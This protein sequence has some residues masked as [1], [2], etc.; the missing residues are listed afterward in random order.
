MVNQDSI[1][2]EELLIKMREIPAKT[3][4]E[5]SIML[6]DWDVSM[7]KSISFKKGAKKPWLHEKLQI[8]THVKCKQKL[9]FRLV[10]LFYGQ[11]DC[12][13]FVTNKFHL[14]KNHL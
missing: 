5:N 4:T 8:L 13:V 10:L 3:I 12:I 11:Y 7:I 2:D 1:T 9:S 14:K 6:K